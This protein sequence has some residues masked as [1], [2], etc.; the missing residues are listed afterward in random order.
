MKRIL[1]AAAAVAAVA[2]IPLAGALA[3]RGPGHKG[4]FAQIDADKNGKITKA[5]AQAF[6]DG[7]FA[8][9][10][11][12]NDGKL[13]RAELEAEVSKR[14]AKQVDRRLKHMDA[15]GDGM[16][17]IEEARAKGDQRFAKMDKNNYG[18]IEKGEVRRKGGHHR[19]KH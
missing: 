17:S 2:A 4:K 1:I 13:S 8:A 6:G 12:N 10:D 19:R 16:I 3:E 9:T 7:K 14:I 15:N 5:E 11:L 18:M